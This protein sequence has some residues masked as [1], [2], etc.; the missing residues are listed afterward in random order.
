MIDIRKYTGRMGNQMFQFAF[1]YSYAKDSG[2]DYY[3][4]DPSNFAGHEQEIKLLFSEGI[5]E[6]IDMVAIHVRRGGN[7]I[8]KDEPN[9]SDNPF[10]VDLSSTDYYKRAMEEFPEAD[11]LVFSD[12]IKWCRQQPIFKKCQFF[13]KDEIQDFNTM[14]SCAGLI[15]A[16]SSYSWWAGYIAPWAK[17][18]IAPK[19]WYSDGVERTKCPDNF[20]RI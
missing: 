2:T 11:F 8:N 9:Y 19:E 6:K 5:K 10:Y 20:I 1:M 15:I 17:K 18:I 12:D 16:N 4:Q 3:F 13:H 7:P 14:A